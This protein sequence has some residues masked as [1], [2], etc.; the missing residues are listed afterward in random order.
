MTP[1]SARRRYALVSFLSWLPT[2][3]L[4][5]PMVLLMSGRGL[6]L[7]EVG[8]VWTVYSVTT[9][10]LELPTGGLA[11]VIGRRMVL[12]ASAAVSVVAM[13]AMAFST[14]MW[15][16]L[17][18]GMLQGAARALS[19]GPAAAWY[20]DTLHDLE[21]PGADLKPGLARGESMASVALCGGVL[22]GGVVPLVVPPALIFPLA[23]PPLLAAAAAVVLLVV[24]VL[25]LPEPTHARRALGSV[26]RE[27]PA[28]VVSG[29]RMAAGRGVLRRLMLLSAV[30]GLALSSVEL[31]TPVRLAQLAGGAKLG[32]TA[33]AAVAALGFAGSA[34]GSAVAPGLAR[35]ARGS[36]RGSAAGHVLAVLALGG[37]AASAGISG[38]PGLACAAA[39]YMVLFAGIGAS[40]LLRM[41]MTHLVVT[42]AERTTMTSIS[43]LSL[44]VGGASS[45]ALLGVLASVWGVGVTWALVAVLVLAATPLFVRLRTPVEHDSV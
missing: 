36:A 20:V 39:A 23:A 27:V 19:S 26:L 45:T 29:L 41:E 44:Q 33:Y 12:A 14:T 1:L 10:T 22:V 16:F 7:A 35:V 8:L 37:L 25:A 13:L 3:L 34:I 21:G 6:S 15:M 42:A 4:L 17:I 32:A 5:G 2:G 43:S 28:T 18:T 40:G 31:L 9:I 38:W 24:V 11:D 30:T